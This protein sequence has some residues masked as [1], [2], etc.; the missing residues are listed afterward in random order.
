MP[1]CT[2]LLWI[3][4]ALN[5]I[6]KSF[7][8]VDYSGHSCVN[9]RVTDVFS[10]HNTDIT[11]NCSFWS[12]QLSW[13]FNKQLLSG[14][15]GDADGTSL[16]L[17]PPLHF[18]NYTCEALPCKHIFNLQPCPPSHLVFADHKH[19]QLNCSLV[20]PTILWKYNNSRLVEFS[21]SSQRARGFGEIARPVYSKFLAT[22]LASYQQLTL[23]FPFISGTYSCHVGSCA[24]TFILFNQ[25]SKAQKYTTN[26]YRN[27]LVL[28]SDST[29]NI[30]LDCACPSYPIV[31][32]H[33]NNS[34]WRAYYHDHL[35]LENLKLDFV[36]FSSHRIVLFFPFTS[37]TTFTCEVITEPCKT[38]FKFLYLP[39][40]S[41][42]LIE[43]LNPPLP[44][45]SP[46]SNSNYWLPYVGLLAI[47]ILFLVNIVCFLPCSRRN[48]RFFQL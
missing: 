27:Q 31:T 16:H 18:G 33:V 13:Y 25:T 45:Q 5:L 21:Y 29:D 2:K 10:K 30:T 4:C 7:T 47:I 1:L 15:W 32:W 6:S 24:E 36:G 26:F 41:V 22:H 38:V 14:S 46:S 42:K 17:K 20:G 28:F 37:N 9:Q 12:L 48:S 34:L 11:L 40:K 3:I 44:S 39:P 43:G 35:V 23:L 8:Y 19:L